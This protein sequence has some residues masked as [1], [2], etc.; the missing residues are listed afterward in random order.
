M[1]TRRSFVAGTA[2]LAASTSAANTQTSIDGWPARPVRVILPT[3][4]G[5]PGENFRLFADH[6][7]S[8]FGQSF[9]PENMPGA[10]GAIGSVAVAR[11]APD[12]HTLLMCSNSHVILAPLVFARSPVDPKRDFVPVA[13]LF[14]FPFLL[15]VHPSL[16][17]HTLAELVAHVKANPGKLNYGSPGIGTG[18]HLVT[19]LLVKRTS[20]EAQHV[21]YQSTAQQVLAAAGGHL[22]FT[23]DT[24]GNARGLVESGKLRPLAVTGPR[25][26]AFMP[27]VPTFEELGHQG[28]DLFVWNGLMAPVGTPPAII[29]ALNREALVCQQKAEVKARMEAGAYEQGMLNPAEFAA[30]VDK[31][32]RTWTNVVRET[33]VRIGS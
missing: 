17:V 7:K 32:L 22:H 13:L 20:M 27:N 14:T 30:L 12:G 24:P 28:F 19:E 10:S 9:V 25:R 4:P 6:Y 11:A 15:L 26:T 18:G 8:V 33:G 1:I 23:F 29:A 3:G 16:P 2:A 21:P 5:G 31:D